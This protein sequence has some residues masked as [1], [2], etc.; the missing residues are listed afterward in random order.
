MTRIFFHHILIAL[1][2]TFTLSFVPVLAHGAEDAEEA[3]VEETEDEEDWDDEDWGDWDDSAFAAYL[4]DEPVVFDENQPVTDTFGEVIAI[5]TQTVKQVRKNQLG[6]NIQHRFGELGPK[7]SNLFGIYAPANARMSLKY[8]VHDRVQ[9][10]VGSTKMGS[11]QDLN[12]KVAILQQKAPKG[13]PLSLSYYGAVTIAAGPADNFDKFSH[14]MAYLHELM[15][16]RKLNDRFSLQLTGS[17]THFNYVSRVDGFRHDNLALTLLGRMNLTSRLALLV[18]VGQGQ[19]LSFIYPSEEAYRSTPL[20]SLGAEMITPGH[21]FQFFLSTTNGLL[22]N[23]IFM[24]NSHS[25]AD[26]MVFAGFNI[27]RIWRL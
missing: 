11:L 2:G 1:L 19:L 24:N 14:R 22:R 23:D 16:A 17:F 20:I 18:E 25:L 27:T 3:E 8:G 21:A 13:M 5:N 12:L 26:G 10:G 9:L 15:V 6:F 4:T 7:L